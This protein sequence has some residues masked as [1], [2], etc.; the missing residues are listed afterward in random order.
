MR[1]LTAQHSLQPQA[2]LLGDSNRSGVV[3]ITTPGQAQPRPIG[4]PPIEKSQ[5]HAGAQ[6]PTGLALPNKHPDFGTSAGDRAL[7]QVE[8]RAAKQPRTIVRE[9]TDDELLSQ[10]VARSR[11]ANELL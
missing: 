6:S 1:A 9:Y 3:P 7:S 8:A 4:E 11:P 2:C 5:E 10:Q